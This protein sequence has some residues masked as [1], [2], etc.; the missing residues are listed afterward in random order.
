MSSSYRPY[1]QRLKQPINQ[2]KW[3]QNGRQLTLTHAVYDYVSS[4]TSEPR[5]YVVVGVV[6]VAAAIKIEMAQK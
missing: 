1:G 2:T 5:A 3:N 4:V 6:I